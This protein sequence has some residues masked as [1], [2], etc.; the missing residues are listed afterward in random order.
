MVKPLEYKKIHCAFSPK[1]KAQTDHSQTPQEDIILH[2]YKK[3][4]TLAIQHENILNVSTKL[5]SVV[6]GMLFSS[7]AL[8]KWLH[9][10][11]ADL[12]HLYRLNIT[13]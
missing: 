7:C 1:D 10:T 6:E 4:N 11:A 5:L 13:L 3:P 8:H 12:I 2:L 9:L